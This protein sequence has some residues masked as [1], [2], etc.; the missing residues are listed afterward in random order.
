MSNLL[1]IRRQDGAPSCFLYGTSLWYT[2]NVVL[3]TDY[4][5]LSSKGLCSPLLFITDPLA[6]FCLPVCSRCGL[7][8]V[9]VNIQ[10]CISVARLH[11]T[12]PHLLP[13]PAFLSF[14]VLQY[15][16]DWLILEKKCFTLPTRSLY[17]KI[18]LPLAQKKKLNQWISL[19][20]CLSAAVRVLEAQLEMHGCRQSKYKRSKTLET[21]YRKAQSNLS[22][23][24][25]RGQLETDGNWEF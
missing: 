13:L 3:P 9:F 7:L 11:W 16:G 12:G 10:Q 8:S 4:I 24:T 14:S 19:A 5:F 6:V 20:W 25:A 15:D 23:T 18:K 17:I 22:T 21:H 1:S 2:V